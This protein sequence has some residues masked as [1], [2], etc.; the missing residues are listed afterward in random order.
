MFPRGFKLA[1]QLSGLRLRL[2]G[3]FDAKRVRL[4]RKV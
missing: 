1:L 3:K 2:F 4:R